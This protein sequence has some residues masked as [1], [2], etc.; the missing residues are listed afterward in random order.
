MA[1]LFVDY[2]G[3]QLSGFIFTTSVIKPSRLGKRTIVADVTS[4]IQKMSFCCV[5][6]LFV[7]QLVTPDVQGWTTH[8]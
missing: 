7:L 2:D 6:N 8:A 3:K 4:I 5:G 1:A